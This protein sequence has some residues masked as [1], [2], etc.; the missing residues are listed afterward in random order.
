[1]ARHPIDTTQAEIE[2]IM[3]WLAEPDAPEPAIEAKPF[4]DDCWS[5]HSK[6]EACDGLFADQIKEDHHQRPEPIEEAPFCDRCFGAHDWL[7][8]CP[9]DQDEEE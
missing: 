5:H 9:A 8:D 3:G 7:A 4:C 2:R 1:M 6:A